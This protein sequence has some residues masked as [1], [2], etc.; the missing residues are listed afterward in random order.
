VKDAAP[1]RVR[2]GGFELD[3][4]AGELREGVR[5]VL[6]QEQPFQ[7]LLMLVEHSGEIVTREDIQ[8]KFW[9]NDTV[10]DFDHGINTAIRKLRKALGDS[11]EEPKYIETLARRGYRFL[12]PVEPEE[13]V[14]SL[15]SASAEEHTPTSLVGRK[16]SHYRVLE[17]IGGG[18]MGVQHLHHL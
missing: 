3:L 18:G 13:G 8:R 17:I 7:S 1:V 14:P 16:V 2:F 6:L 12:V 4:R 11:P 10:V 5:K 15:H 9:P